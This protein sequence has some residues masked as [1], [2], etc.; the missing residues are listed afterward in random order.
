MLKVDVTTQCEKCRAPMAYYAMWIQGSLS[1]DRS[2]PLYIRLICIDCGST[3]ELRVRIVHGSA[4]EQEA[5]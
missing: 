2:Q 5:T 1:E 3:Q 4:A